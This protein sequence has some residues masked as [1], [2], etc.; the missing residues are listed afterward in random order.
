MCGVFAW[1]LAVIAVATPQWLA[2]SWFVYDT[3]GYLLGSADLSTSPILLTAMEGTVLGVGAADYRIKFS[4][5]SDDA[6]RSDLQIVGNAVDN[7]T[8]YDYFGV[9]GFCDEVNG[10]FR[11]PGEQ[12]AMLTVGAI[13]VVSLA[14]AIAFAF[15]YIANASRLMRGLGFA[16]FLLSAALEITHFALALSGNYYNAIRDGRAGFLVPSGDPASGANEYVL[17]VTEPSD[18]VYLGLGFWAALFAAIFALIAAS[19][20]AVP[21]RTLPA[22]EEATPPAADTKMADDLESPSPQT[23]THV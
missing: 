7:M 11:V 17:V 14:L 16:T 2:V 4:S 9:H 1:V 5:V 19:S 6:C 13:A 18:P 22:L 20:M 10:T 15:L 12:I 21:H 3:E 23:I 8:A